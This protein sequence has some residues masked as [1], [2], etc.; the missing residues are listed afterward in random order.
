MI[1]CGDAVETWRARNRHTALTMLRTCFVCCLP[2]GRSQ[3]TKIQPHHAIECE[4]ALKALLPPACAEG[5]GSVCRWLG[6]WLVFRQPQ[7]QPTRPNP[8]ARHRAIRRGTPSTGRRRRRG[9]GTPEW[10]SSPTRHGSRPWAGS[11]S[12]HTTRRRWVPPSAKACVAPR[13]LVSDRRTSTVG[14]GGTKS[15][16]RCQAPKLASPLDAVFPAAQHRGAHATD[17]AA[18]ALCQAVPTTT[19]TGKDKD[20]SVDVSFDFVRPT[21]VTQV[22]RGVGLH[23]ADVEGRAVTMRLGRLRLVN[24]CV[25]A[26]RAAWV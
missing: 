3:E 26:I 21:L 19:P 9:R 2:S 24:T 17:D 22:R 16:L 15:R 14:R 20:S 23:E 4:A 12:I 10:P 1:L 25:C 13:R 18:A 8:N 6:G 5:L 11:A 7:V